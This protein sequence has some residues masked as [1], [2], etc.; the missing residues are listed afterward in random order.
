MNKSHLEQ[1]ANN[2]VSAGVEKEM[3]CQL[4]LAAWIQ[5]VNDSK[6]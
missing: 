1:K 2:E 5:S 3:I 6:I 4:Q